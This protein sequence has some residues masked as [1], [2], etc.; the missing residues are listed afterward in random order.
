MTPEQ[1]TALYVLVARLEEKLGPVLEQ[2]AGLDTRVTK[3]EKLEVKLVA[4]GSAIGAGLTVAAKYLLP[5][6]LVLAFAHGVLLP[7][8]AKAREK[9]QWTMQPLEE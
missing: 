2:V 1:Y 9:P 7:S 8:H 5:A 3:L 4:Y 6:T